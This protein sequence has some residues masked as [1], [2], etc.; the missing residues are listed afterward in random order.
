MKFY[1]HV[2]RVGER[3][4]VRGYEDGR[5]FKDMVEYKPYIFIRT[6]GAKIKPEYKTLDGKSVS[7][8]YPGSMKETADYISEYSDVGGHEIFGVLPYVYQNK[9]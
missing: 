5:A 6:D 4:L 8:F 9:N 7:K 2:A 3:L 1:T